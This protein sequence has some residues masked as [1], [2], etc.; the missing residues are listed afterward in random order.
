MRHT[1]RYC[2]KS[3]LLCAFAVAVI[4]AQALAHS[5]AAP[6]SKQLS[7]QEKIQRLL[8]FVEK[9]EV[10]FIRNGV[11]YAPKDAAAHMRY[12][13]DYAGKR[14]KT[15]E[16]F[17]QHIASKS[18]VSGKPYMVRTKD[19]KEMEAGKWLGD[20]LAR[21]EVSATVRPSTGNDAPLDE[22]TAS[23]IALGEAAKR[24]KVEKESLRAISAEEH[25]GVWT[26]TVAR[27]PETPG[28]H[29]TVEV[30]A[31]GEIVKYV[32]GR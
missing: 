16:Q 15:A 18:S 2:Y 6:P 32:P 3:R 4:S 30:S 23:Q 27:Q 20:E 7:E 11:E 10:T 29:C 13:L 9:S 24:M 22:K 1:S 12:K 25:D 17:I 26:V 19:G 21:L 28:G 31:K 8:T 5:D 14:V